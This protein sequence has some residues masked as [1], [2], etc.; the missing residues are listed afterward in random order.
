[1]VKR[2]LVACSWAVRFVLWKLAVLLLLLV[3][4]ARRWIGAP[5]QDPP[6][7]ASWTNEGPLERQV[8]VSHTGQ[9]KCA[10]NF[11]ASVLKPAL[12]AAG[13]TVFMDFSNLEPGSEWPRE[14]AVA[15]ANSV[16]VVV[17]LS[18]Q[19]TKRKWCMQ[20]LDL[21]LHSRRLAGKKE[22]PLV[23]PV[24][25]DSESDILK[26]DEIA[27]YW[28]WRLLACN[29]D[30]VEPQCWTENICAMKHERQFV[31]CRIMKAKDKEAAMA[32]RVVAAAMKAMPVQQ[33]LSGRVFGREHQVEQLLTLAPGRLGVWLHGMGGCGKTT[34][35]RLLFNQL[36]PH[37]QHRAYLSLEYKQAISSMQL[38]DV[39]KQLGAT[40]QHSLQAFGDYVRGRAV[41][42]V[43]DNIWTAGQLGQL[44]PK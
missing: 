37:F 25:Y 35:A 40:G 23:I 24:F 44:L 22:Q 11:A 7:L 17:V 33:P 18:R 42:L 31:A 32:E 21:A 29:E 41:L 39:L 15:A 30:G 28:Q 4:A 5:R 19:F 13:L 27:F 26:P 8:F 9:D 6:A 12:E 43:V 34:I 16:V 2:L 36:S 3:E 1:M 38:Q 20:E 10:C 14:L